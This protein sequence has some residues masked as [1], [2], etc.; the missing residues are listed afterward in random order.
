MW[1]Q[2]EEEEEIDKELPE[3]E[4]VEWQRYLD[5]IRPRWGEIDCDVHK[6]KRP[7]FQDFPLIL[8]YCTDSEYLIVHN[9]AINDYL[10]KLV[11]SGTNEN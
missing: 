7:K 1:R 3:S 6:R 9:R 11:T 4:E 8:S 2:E 10:D 5:S